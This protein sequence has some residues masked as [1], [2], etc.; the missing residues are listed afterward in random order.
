MTPRPIRI[1]GVNG[2]GLQGRCFRGEVGHLSL[3]TARRTFVPY[4]ALS[5]LEVNLPIG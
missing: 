5:C 2:M 4:V 1:P 3:R